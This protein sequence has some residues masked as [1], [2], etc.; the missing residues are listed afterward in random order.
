MNLI[1]QLMLYI[2]FAG[3]VLIF[4]A[5]GWVTVRDYFKKKAAAKADSAAAAEAAVQAR[6]DAAVAAAATKNTAV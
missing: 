3:V 5:G 6:I 4:I 1:E 2:S